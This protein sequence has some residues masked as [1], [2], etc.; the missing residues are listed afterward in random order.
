MKKNCFRERYSAQWS[1]DVDDDLNDDLKIMNLEDDN[2]KKQ[3]MKSLWGWN[4][5]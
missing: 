4:W 5:H 2:L 1:D 3:N